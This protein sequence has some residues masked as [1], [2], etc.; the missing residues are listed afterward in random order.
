MIDF[1]A[2]QAKPA[3]VPEAPVKRKPKFSPFLQPLWE[4]YQHVVNGNETLAGQV[5]SQ[6]LST[7]IP[8]DE[9][10]SELRQVMNHIRTLAGK[11]VGENGERMGVRFVTDHQPD[12]TAFLHFWAIPKTD[13]DEPTSRKRKHG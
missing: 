10:T 7:E 2:L 11:Q 12:G 5:V 4:S 6:A 9:S 8:Q 1:T 13:A 3:P